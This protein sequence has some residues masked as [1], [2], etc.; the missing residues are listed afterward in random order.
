MELT[1][2]S[3]HDTTFLK[4]SNTQLADC[5]ILGDKG[6]LSS[7]LQLD[8]FQTAN[9]RLETPMRANQLNY[10]SSFAG[11]KSLEMRTV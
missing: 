11:V 3:V 9:I 1:K 2:A 7:S 4:E 6:Y 5:V 8:L 10:N